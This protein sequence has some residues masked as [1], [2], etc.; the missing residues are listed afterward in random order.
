MLALA[1]DRQE[2]D[3]ESLL[4]LTRRLIALRHASP[5]LMTGSITI[6]QAGEALLLFERE[7]EG[8][9]LLCAFNLGDSALP[10]PAA[11]HGRRVVQAINGGNPEL[12]PPFAA[13][14]AE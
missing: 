12:L 13:L 2:G 11:L 3:P 4:N 14:I 1:V 7:A 9:T 10:A 5:A 8:Q 6:R